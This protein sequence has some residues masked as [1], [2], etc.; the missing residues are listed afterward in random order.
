[1]G[2][3]KVREARRLRSGRQDVRRG[4]GA[5]LGGQLMRSRPAKARESSSQVSVWRTFLRC[6][7][8]S[9]WA[10]CWARFMAFEA[11]RA[12]AGMEA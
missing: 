3:R 6:L 5:D 12:E 11:S 2:G 10:R 7:E 9:F 8:A 4:R 1:M